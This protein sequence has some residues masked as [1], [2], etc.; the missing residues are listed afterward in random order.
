LRSFLFIFLAFLFLSGVAFSADHSTLQPVWPKAPAA[1]ENTPAPVDVAALRAK[2]EKGDAQAQANL[3]F[4]YSI[5]GFLEHGS[6]QVNQD[7][8]KDYAEAAKWFHMAADQNEFRAQKELGN[9]YETGQ[10]V[11]QDWIEAYFWLSVA[12]RCGV[13][14]SGDVW[15]GVPMTEKEEQALP[16]RGVAKY[17]TSIQEDAAD[18]RVAEW[19]KVHHLRCWHTPEKFR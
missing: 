16:S 5:G 3:G 1:P 6:F 10:G 8:K 14:G 19:I 9:L 15:I 18:K 4:L 2:A 13:G 17:L 7:V 11:K 12:E